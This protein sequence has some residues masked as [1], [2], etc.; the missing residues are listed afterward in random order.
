MP[1]STLR[2]RVTGRVDPEDYG[3]ET[4]FSLEEERKLVEHIQLRAELGYGLS[5]ASTQR[6]AGEMAYEMKRRKNITPMS[7]NWLYSFLKRWE[8]SIKTIKPRQ[9]VSA[10]AK[11]SIPE[12]FNNYF[13]Q[14]KA[15]LEEHNLLGKPYRI[16]NVDET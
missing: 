7:N 2:D 13:T 3:R 16:F 9:L 6:L 14:L 1:N 12:A 15:V 8:S 4:I 10:R 11:S 5:N